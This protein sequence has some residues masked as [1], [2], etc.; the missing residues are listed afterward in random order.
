MGCI[1]GSYGL[2][3]KSMWAPCGHD[4]HLWCMCGTDV[5]HVGVQV[6]KEELAALLEAQQDV[7][8]AMQ[9]VQ[10]SRRLDEEQQEQQQQHLADA[11]AQVT[12]LRMLVHG[13]QAP[14]VSP[15]PCCCALCLCFKTSYLCGNLFC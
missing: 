11:E 9:S 10:S 7:R 2:Q 8:R 3:V 6:A 1:W 15:P 13:P 14:A 4:M 12:K 5:I